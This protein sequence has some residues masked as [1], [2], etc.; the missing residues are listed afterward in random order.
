MSII[1]KNII[2][3]KLYG[4][5]FAAVETVS[6]STIRFILPRDFARIPPRLRHGSERIP[7]R[8]RPSIS[9]VLADRPA[10]A[11]SRQALT[12]EPVLE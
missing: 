1:V 9:R 5:K 2:R 3:L 8:F 11:M 10:C 4:T 12:A 6:A 7:A